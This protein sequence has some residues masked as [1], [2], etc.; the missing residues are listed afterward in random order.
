ML[1]EDSYKNRKGKNYLSSSYV[2]DKVLKDDP[3]IGEDNT[4]S[5]FKPKEDNG[6]SF[7]D[8]VS[9]AMQEEISETKDKPKLKEVKRDN[10]KVN[11]VKRK[12]GIKKSKG[13]D[14]R[15]VLLVFLLICIA[16][17]VFFLLSS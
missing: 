1:K 5:Q 8:L 4:S 3:F 16:G 12:Q 17:V 11:V 7:L 14:G 15:V 10:Q 2:V 9:Q 13:I 6:D